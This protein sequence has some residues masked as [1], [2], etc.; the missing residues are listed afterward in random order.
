MI[1]DL[2]CTLVFWRHPNCQHQKCRLWLHLT[3]PNNANANA[4]ANAI[5]YIL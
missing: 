5:T 3:K 4:N 2:K 1:P